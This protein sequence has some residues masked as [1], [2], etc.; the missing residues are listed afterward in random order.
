MTHL[1]L[2]FP[3]SPL[4]MPT[5]YLSRL[6]DRNLSPD[7]WTFCLDLGLDFPAISRGDPASVTD[8]C[9][10][11][12]IPAESFEG[13]T[14]IKTSSMKY[15]LGNEVM[16]TETLARGEIR[17]CPVCI[18][19]S[20]EGG[21]CSWEV[22]HELHWQFIHIRRCWRHG[23]ALQSHRT[24]VDASSRYDFTAFVRDAGYDF[25]QLPKPTPAEADELDTYLTKRAYGTHEENWCNRLEI[26]A[27]I[28]ACEAFGVLIDHGRDMHVSALE[29]DQ[30]RNAM[31]TGFRI[32]NQ[33]SDGICQALDRF[34]RRTPS[35]GGNQ[36][37]PS[38]GAVQRLLGSHAKQRADLNPIRDVVRE[39]FLDHY[40]FRSGTTVLGQK[41]TE[42]RVFSIRGACR[43]IGIR[44]SLLEEI[45]IRRGLAYRDDAGQFNLETVLKRTLIEEIKRDK[46][47]YLDQNQT[48][49]LLGCSYVM[50]KKLQRAGILRPAEGEN[51]RRPKGFYR[52]AVLDFLTRL[53]V[54]AERTEATDPRRCTLELVARKLNCGVPDVVQLML[55]GKIQAVGRL[56]DELRLD[57][58]VVSIK[59]VAQALNFTEPNG[60]SM[61]EVRRR[62]FI[63]AR[64]LDYLVENHFLEVKRM[65]HSVTRATRDYITADS[66]SSFTASFITAGMFARENGLNGKHGANLLRKWGPKPINSDPGLR[67]IFRREELQTI[68]F[69]REE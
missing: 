16:N 33:G 10:L 57:S 68:S 52:P 2:T 58:L 50:I 5:S 12:N 4:E 66:M 1:A 11:A 13:R 19:D 25:W 65:R 18:S 31:L 23:V 20:L 21:G 34:N 35:R 69:K 61:K 43:E 59:D 24:M 47:D 14:V 37:H 6:A 63:N 46:H 27:L 67:S 48:A 54:N 62:L 40:P 7:L 51:R 53:G 56:T 30:R 42:T 41:I 44:R 60:F 28:K 3:S 38:N 8:I 29:T 9:A 15:Q 32:L 39:Y 17:Y 22:I 36:P 49:D 64:T 45:L 55:E 26:P